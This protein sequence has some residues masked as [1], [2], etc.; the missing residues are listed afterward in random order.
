MASHGK[1]AIEYGSNLQVLL[2]MRRKAFIL[3]ANCQLN[4][5]GRASKRMLDT[6]PEKSKTGLLFGRYRWKIFTAV[7][8]Q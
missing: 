3:A 4:A 6:K 7:L 8:S 2:R 5:F 1:K